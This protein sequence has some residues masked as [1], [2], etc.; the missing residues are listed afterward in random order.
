MVVGDAA[1]H[2]WSDRHG[3]FF[4]IKHAGIP[5]SALLAGLSVPLFN[6]RW[7]WRWSFVAAAIIG[8]L[9]LLLI[10]RAAPPAQPDAAKSEQV[11]IR[12]ARGDLRRL[13]VV[14]SLVAMAPG[15]LG[16]FTISAGL[17]AGL[18]EG[19]AGWVLSAAGLSTI[20]AR[21]L[22]GTWIDRRGASGIRLLVLVVGVGALSVVGLAFA[23]GMWF[24]FMTVAAFVAAWVWPGL[25]TYTVVLGNSDR[26]A[27]AT[28]RTQA[29]I[30][31]GAGLGPP[32]FGWLVDRVE[33]RGAWL[34]IVMVLAVGAMV[35]YPLIGGRK[36]TSSVSR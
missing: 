14:A 13:T 25:L 3:T 33:F 15:A 8:V 28:A 23:R 1:H 31:V 27:E 6:L 20:L 36:T 10:P 19:A 16:M 35:G 30:F 21:G 4:G 22:Y 18:S 2:G 7:G 17:A 24:A 9:L 29:G 12:M 32:V 11:R 34:A 5:G 26:P